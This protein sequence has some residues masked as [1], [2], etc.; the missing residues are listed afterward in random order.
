[1]P[2]YTGI[3]L[4]VAG[5]EPI[6]IK[7]YDINNL[8]DEIKLAFWTIELGINPKPIEEQ[9]SEFKTIFK[10]GKFLID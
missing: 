10:D 3:S 5:S 2:Q 7:N 6:V 9:I 4:S 8:P 1:M